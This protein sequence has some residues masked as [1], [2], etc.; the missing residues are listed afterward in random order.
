[1]I[2][3]DSARAI[4]CA[5]ASG[6]TDVK[7]YAHAGMYYIVI[8]YV[9]DEHG[10]LTKERAPSWHFRKWAYPTQR[11]LTYVSS[12]TGDKYGTTSGT[13]LNGSTPIYLPMRDHSDGT[14]DFSCFEE[15]STTPSWPKHLGMNA[16]IGYMTVFPAR[17]LAPLCGAIGSAGE[18]VMNQQPLITIVNYREKHALQLVSQLCVN[19]GALCTVASLSPLFCSPPFTADP[20]YP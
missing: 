18:I 3:A 14:R 20:L 10:A 1:M 11:A 9:R 17:L 8:V 19:I 5:T 13:T 2:T 16:T 15:N 6:S 12:N 7:A 4:S